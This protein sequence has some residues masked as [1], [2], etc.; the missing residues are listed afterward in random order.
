MG[1]GMSNE[2]CSFER[3]RLVELVLA[4]HLPLHRMHVIS[5]C[6]SLSFLQLFEGR[7]DAGTQQFF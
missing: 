7:N 4:S 2:M 5:D 3:L 1:E 6:F